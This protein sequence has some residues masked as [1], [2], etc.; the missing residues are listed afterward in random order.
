MLHGA[1]TYMR[2]RSVH[3]DFWNNSKIDLASAK[4]LHNTVRDIDF[5]LNHHLRKRFTEGHQKTGK[6]GHSREL[7]ATETQLPMECQIPLQRF[8][9]PVTYSQNFFCDREKLLPSFC[10]SR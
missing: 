6:P 2:L 8:Q 7:G 9:C 5:R 3:Y 10:Q 1:E 4:P